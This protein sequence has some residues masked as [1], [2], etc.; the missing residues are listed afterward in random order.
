LWRWTNAI[1]SFSLAGAA[2][3]DE[4]WT[5]RPAAGGRGV[6]G[7]QRQVVMNSSNLF[8]ELPRI[9]MKWKLFSSGLAQQIYRRFFWDR[10]QRNKKNF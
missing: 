4:G 6:R 10:E 8:G 5:I 2:K 7:H 3:R 1:I 9:K